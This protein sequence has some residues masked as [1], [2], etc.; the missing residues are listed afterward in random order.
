MTNNTSNRFAPV[1]LESI[2][3][4]V[5]L[6]HKMMKELAAFLKDPV[7]ASIPKPSIDPDTQYLQFYID[8]NALANLN[9]ISKET[10]CDC[11]G[12]FFGLDPN[13]GNK[14]TACFVGLNDK[15]EI[16]GKHFEKKMDASGQPTAVDALPGEEN[17]PPPP[18]TK[19]EFALRGKRPYFTVSSEI[20]DVENYF[21]TPAP[22]K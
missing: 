12:V 1:S 13:K 15:K 9:T 6:Y 16:I 3:E 21:V 18:E 19:A 2:K 4:Q 22:A 10:D 20:N 8:K 7:N 5:G 17:W 11:L 14:I